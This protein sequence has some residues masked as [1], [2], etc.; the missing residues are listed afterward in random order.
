MRLKGP[1]PDR[2]IFCPIEPFDAFVV[3][4]HPLSPQQCVESAIAEPGA[5]RRQVAES[6]PQGSFAGTSLWTI[7][8]S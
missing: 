5:L 8:R 1:P 4:P 6:L 7:A 3:E 2:Q